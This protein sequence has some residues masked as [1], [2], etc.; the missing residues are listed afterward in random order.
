[1]ID[2]MEWINGNADNVQKQMIEQSEQCP[3]SKP[4]YPHCDLQKL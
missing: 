1:M 3:P 2:G 4:R